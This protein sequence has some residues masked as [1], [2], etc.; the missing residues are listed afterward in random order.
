M[1]QC[2]VLAII[3][4]GKLWKTELFLWFSI[5][6]ILFSGAWCISQWTELIL[7]AAG[8]RRLSVSTAFSGISQVAI[9]NAAFGSYSSGNPA[10]LANNS[11]SNSH[12]HHHHRSPSPPQPPPLPSFP[13]K[14]TMTLSQ[15]LSFTPA[16]N[17]YP[18]NAAAAT[19]PRNKYPPADVRFRPLAF[20]DYLETIL[21]PTALVA[22]THSRQQQS[23]FTIQLSA[24]NVD[25]IRKACTGHPPDYSVQVQLRFCRCARD[26]RGTVDV[27]DYLPSGIAVKLNSKLVALPVSVRCKSQTIHTLTCIPHDRRRYAFLVFFHFL[28][29]YVQPPLPTSKPNAEAKRCV[30]SLQL[31]R[32]VYFFSQLYSNNNFGSIVTVATFCLGHPALWILQNSVNCLFMTMR[33][34]FS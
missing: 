21:P 24:A 19:P 2:A 7:V 3:N 20:Y 16:F 31:H 15:A 28:F 8:R 9:A 17:S 30:L 32:I 18:A 6:L 14:A 27:D 11:S 23:M 34:A 29:A 26:S 13:P 25:R 33:L 1:K 22:E 10:S 4:I 5:I 12:H